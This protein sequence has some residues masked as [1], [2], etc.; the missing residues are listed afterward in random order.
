VTAL[1]PVEAVTISIIGFFALIALLTF[2]RIW[3][4]KAPPSYRRFRVGVFVERD[5]YSKGD[6]HGEEGEAR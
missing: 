4:R 5:D 2:A 6:E 3:L 1:A